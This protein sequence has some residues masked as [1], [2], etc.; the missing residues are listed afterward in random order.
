MEN[1]NYRYKPVVPSIDFNVTGYP[2]LYCDPGQVDFEYL[3]WL[4]FGSGGTADAR[5]CFVDDWRLEHLWRRQGQGLAK[6][7]LTG[8]ITAPDFTIEKS[9]HLHLL[10]TRYGDL[11]SLQ[12]TGKI[13]AL[14]LFRCCNGG[15]LTVGNCLYLQ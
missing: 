1:V 3:K 14:R 5:H 6:A 2:E 7:I 8:I 13:T 9:I 15:V 12:N 4:R 10:T 11:R